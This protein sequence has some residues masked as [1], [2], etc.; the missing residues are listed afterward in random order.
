MYGFTARHTALSD[1]VVVV[2][3]RDGV[4]DASARDSW[5]RSSLGFRVDLDGS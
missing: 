5:R 3:S 2:A 4:A 1:I